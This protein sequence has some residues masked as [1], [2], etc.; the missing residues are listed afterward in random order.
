M[1]IQIIHKSQLYQYFPQSIQQRAATWEFLIIKWQF[2]WRLRMSTC[3]SPP[4]MTRSKLC[5]SRWT[6]S[7]VSFIIIS[8]SQLSSELTLMN[9][10]LKNRDGAD[11]WEC[12]PAARL[13]GRHAWSSARRVGHSQKSA[14]S[15]FSIVNWVVNWLLR[16]F[17]CSSP[18]RTTRSRL[19]ASR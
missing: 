12:L 14:L 10:Y 13:H 19:C 15:S 1:T 7:K 2:C 6:F 18:P 16:I 4:R 5:A 17:T 9:F 3:S 11:I 8:H